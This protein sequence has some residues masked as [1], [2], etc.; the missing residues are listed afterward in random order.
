MLRMSTAPA[1]DYAPHMAPRPDAL[2]IT[3]AYVRIHSSE[4]LGLRSRRATHVDHPA[5]KPMR[6]VIVGA[7]A[8]GSSLAERLSGD[9][10]DVAIIEADREKAAQVQEIHDPLIITGNGA[11]Q[12]VLST[13]EA[14]KADLLIA[15]STTTARPHQQLPDH[16]GHR[17]VA[18][19]LLDD[20]RK[21]GDSS[22][23]IAI[24]LL[25][26]ETVKLL[27]PRPPYHLTDANRYRRIR[28]GRRG[29]GS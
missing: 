17:Q 2:D 16:P 7:E 19:V 27:R 26:V 12:S 28:S 14:G 8:V 24:H 21:A 29:P 15:V 11:G 13:A 18:A 9:G 10:Q 3:M 5:R 6:I 4:P 22:R 20:C 25:F 23:D 1:H